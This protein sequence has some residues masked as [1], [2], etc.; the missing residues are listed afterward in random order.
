MISIGGLVWS[1]WSGHCYSSSVAFALCS[2]NC[3]SQGWPKL[4]IAGVA[5]PA[6]LFFVGSVPF[7][8]AAF[9]QFYQTGNASDF[10]QGDTASV[11]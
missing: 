4:P 6:S 7:T 10:L 9:L 1:S 11:Q 8:V 2:Q 5:N 3:Q